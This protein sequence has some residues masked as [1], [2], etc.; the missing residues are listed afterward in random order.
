MNCI[1]AIAP[2]FLAVAPLLLLLSAGGCG[3]P[4]SAGKDLRV[5]NEVDLFRF[6]I[7]DMK[8]YSQTFSFTWTHSGTVGAV[9][10]QYSS[11]SGGDATLVLKDASGTTVYSRSLKQNGQFT[12]EVGPPGYWTV[13]I[14]MNKVS[15]SVAMQA[16]PN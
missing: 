1:R 3:E 13:Q 5:T 2:R 6:Q 14:L 9:V 11:I 7:S 15:G 12:S 16:A 8:N 4:Y 10:D